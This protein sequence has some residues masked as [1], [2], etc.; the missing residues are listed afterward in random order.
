MELPQDATQ[1][2]LTRQ[3]RLTVWMRR[4]DVTFTSLADGYELHFS[5]L[6]RLCGQETMPTRH[7]AYLVGQSIP[8]ELLPLAL[9]QKPG[10]KPR[11]KPIP[12]D[13]AMA[14]FRGP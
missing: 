1:L 5:Q 6:A 9:D 2:P 3:E 7:H 11:P 12:H 8:V 4:N 13:V 10:P 14:A